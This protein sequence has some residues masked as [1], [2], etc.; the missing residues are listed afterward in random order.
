VLYGS[1]KQI[2]NFDNAVLCYIGSL[3]M[4]PDLQKKATQSERNLF[5]VDVFLLR[6]A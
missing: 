2:F 6:R 4:V 5:K 3:I 1:T